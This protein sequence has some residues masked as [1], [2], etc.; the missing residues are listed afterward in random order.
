[1]TYSDRI[2]AIRDLQKDVLV[3]RDAEIDGIWMVLLSG[4]HGFLFGPPGVAK[5]LTIED[6]TRYFPSFNYFGV[7]MSKMTPPEELFGPI[8]MSLLKQ[9]RFEYQTEGYLPTADL[10]F[11]DEIWKS[12]ATILNTLL[13]AM[14]ERVFR[15]GTQYH[16]M[17]LKSLFGASNELPSETE[18]AALYDRFLF[19][20]YVQDLKGAEQFETLLKH[21]TKIKQYLASAPID[22]FTSEEFEEIRE[23]VD[24]VDITPEITSALVDIRDALELEKG[25]TVSSRRW[26]NSLQGIRAHAYLHGRDTAI[27][28]DLLA[29]TNILWSEPEQIDEVSQVVWEKANP[30]LH[31]VSK[32][33]DRISDLVTDTTEAI[34][35]AQNGTKEGR[36]KVMAEYNTKWSD[37]VDEIQIVR[38]NMQSRTPQDFDKHHSNLNYMN[39]VC[40]SQKMRLMIGLGRINPDVIGAEMVEWKPEKVSF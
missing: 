5:T 35:G 33:R 37:M 38:A 9:D 21:E 25:I 14:N 19:R 28:Y 17:P 31:T 32:L 3:A 39:D 40:S 12:G 7:L 2:E 29:L 24:S 15:N 16:K 20:F 13:K 27:K 30:A 4:Q 8:S 36:D 11:L 6:V 10:A 22:T 26:L 1:M 23:E 18:L 34:Q